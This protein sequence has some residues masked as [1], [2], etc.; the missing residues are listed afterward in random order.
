MKVAVLACLQLADQAR[1]LEQEIAELKSRDNELV[2]LKNVEQEL[3]TLKGAEL[4][5]SKLKA[6]VASKSREFSV[7]LDEAL[8]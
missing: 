4:E 1:G 7:L 3:A 5:L 8:K 2:A 6:Q